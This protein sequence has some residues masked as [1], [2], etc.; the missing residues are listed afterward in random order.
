GDPQWRHH[1]HRV[2]RRKIALAAC[3]AG[4]LGLAGYFLF[5]GTGPRGNVI[6][7]CADGSAATEIP[8]DGFSC[9][10]NLGD[11][12]AT[13]VDSSRHGL[14]VRVRNLEVRQDSPG[15]LSLVPV[16]GPTTG[17]VVDV[18]FINIQ[19][20]TMQQ[21]AVLLPDSSKVRLNAVS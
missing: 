13:T 3:L 17:K 7:D 2:K 16:E 19:T 6:G 21:Y 20:D 10:L 4:T 14:I 18:P 12:I 15:I 11:S 9:T 5:T 1:K 8:L